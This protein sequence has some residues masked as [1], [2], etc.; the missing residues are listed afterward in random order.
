[1]SKKVKIKVH[2][3]ETKLRHQSDGLQY[4]FVDNLK[5]V[6]SKLRNIV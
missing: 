6:F 5:N 1:M 3:R 2:K 4:S